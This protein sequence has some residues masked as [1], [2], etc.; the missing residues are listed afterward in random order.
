MTNP[1][2]LSRLHWEYIDQTLKLHGVDTERRKQIGY[3]YRTAMEHGYKH[4]VDEALK[5]PLLAITVDGDK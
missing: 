2:E 3:H 1:K 4:G 5:Y